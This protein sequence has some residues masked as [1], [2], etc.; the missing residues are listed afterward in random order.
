MAVNIDRIYQNVLAMANKEQRGYI[1]PQEF[2]LYAD[3]A[4]IDIF[5]RYFH[6]IRQAETRME[7]DMEFSS[8]VNIL[9]EKI[10][11]FRNFDTTIYATSFDGKMTLPSD[12][13]R[14]ESISY[15]TDHNFLSMFTT[16]QVVTTDTQTS[17]FVGA[18]SIKIEL[19]EVK[20]KDISNLIT[21]LTRPTRR[22]PVFVRLNNSTVQVYPH[23]RNYN[24]SAFMGPG[25]Y[26]SWN[27]SGTNVTLNTSSYDVVFDAGYQDLLLINALYQASGTW[28]KI[29]GTGIP[30]D[31]LVTN[32][33]LGATNKV[34]IN[35]LPTQ[36]GASLAYFAAGNTKCDYIRRPTTPN[37]GYTEIN[38][39]AL[40]NSANST[41][42]ELHES[43]ESALVVKILLLAGITLKDNNV[44][45]IGAA[46]EGKIIQSQKQ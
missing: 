29:I 11:V 8:A 21:D 20:K 38:G 15:Y 44:I 39:A 34:T 28:P 12:L 14:L 4:Q 27:T 16:N 41:D 32:I 37:W 2:N 24:F 35:K 10:S 45:Q 7:G 43:E 46:E 30:N 33:S 36:A 9:D 19:E 1:T 31:T 3:Q 13:Y 5:E 26:F 22:R 40:Y 42:F 6:D 18:R 23:T 25:Q 17:G